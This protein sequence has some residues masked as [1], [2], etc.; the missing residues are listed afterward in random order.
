MD[1]LELD[2]PSEERRRRRVPVE[3]LQ[4]EQPGVKPARQLPPQ[5]AV[6]REQPRPLARAHERA[7]RLRGGWN[8]AA[9]AVERAEQV[10][11]QPDEEAEAVVLLRQTV[12]ERLVRRR[13]RP[14]SVACAPRRAASS[15]ASTPASAADARH[16][17]AVDVEMRR[18][19]REEADAVGRLQP[20]VRAPHVGAEQ[21]RQHVVADRR[22][23]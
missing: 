16:R 6:E 14:R 18:E 8:T 12:K 5:R 17:V 7:R 23:R 21:R 22:A 2:Q 9:A 10:G 19:H 1:A 11:A 3:A 13:Q 20:G 4:R 15:A